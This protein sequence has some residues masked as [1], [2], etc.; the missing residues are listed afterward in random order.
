MSSTTET[1]FEPVTGSYP[2]LKLVEDIGSPEVDLN[3]ELLKQESERCAL[4]YLRYFN[5]DREHPRNVEDLTESEALESFIVHKTSAFLQAIEEY[6]NYSRALKWQPEHPHAPASEINYD[7]F[8]H[9]EQRAIDYYYRYIN[10]LSS[11]ICA[12]IGLCDDK[13][14]IY[15]MLD[16]LDHDQ[17]PLPI[18]PNPGDHYRDSGY[19]AMRP[20]ISTEEFDECKAFVLN[21]AKTINLYD[22][23]QDIYSENSEYDRARVLGATGLSAVS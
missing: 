6:T 23:A 4:N 21:Y 7:K 9:F 16:P 17:S 1:Y 20:Y 15:P 14:P 19:G 8:G 12:N 5:S 2:K 18:D 22:R 3:S 10:G 13:G 11:T